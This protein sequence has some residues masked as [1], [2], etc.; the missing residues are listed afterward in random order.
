MTNIVK[1][2]AECQVRETC[3]LVLCKIPSKKTQYYIAMWLSSQG[4][5]EPFIGGIYYCRS[6]NNNWTRNISLW[7]IS[8][9]VPE[10]FLLIHVYLEIPVNGIGFALFLFF[11]FF[12]LK[13]LLF[14]FHSRRAGEPGTPGSCPYPPSSELKRGVLLPSSGRLWYRQLAEALE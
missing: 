1:E 2:T 4:F 10:G 11:F 5:E 13:C 6:Y 3:T 8:Y 14:Y 7:E 12:P 9:L